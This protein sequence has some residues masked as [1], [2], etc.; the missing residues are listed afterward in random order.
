MQGIEI[1]KENDDWLVL[2]KP[3]GVSVHNR[4][5][6]DLISFVKARS[7]SADKAFPINR[8]DSGTCGLVL[9]AKNSKIA[10]IL[11]QSF[12]KRQVSKIYLARV[13]VL[14][15]PPEVGATGLWRWPLTNRAEGRKDPKGFWG[16]RI[17]CQTQW[18]VMAVTDD[19]AILKIN[20]LTGRKHQIRRHCAIYGWPIWGDPRY[21]PKDVEFEEGHNLIAK[22]L[23][24]TD[25]QSGELVT[26]TSKFQLS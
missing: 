10:T 8:L 23:S 2:D 9:F 3:Q 19:S 6:V 15:N 12:E 20:L 21:G 18:Q 5:G 7:G 24:F 25:P 4:Q 11:Q 13:Q 22:E 1:I 26:V 14:R 17:P 16:K